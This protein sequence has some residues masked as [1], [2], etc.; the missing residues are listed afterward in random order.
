MAPDHCSLIKF[1]PQ[2][3]IQRQMSQNMRSDNL[4]WTP[5][6]NLTNSLIPSALPVFHDRLPAE[7]KKC[8]REAEAGAP[9]TCDTHGQS[10]VET[11]MRSCWGQGDR[12]PARINEG[13]EHGRNTGRSVMKQL[14]W[15]LGKIGAEAWDVGMAVPANKMDSQSTF[16]G[17]LTDERGRGHQVFLSWVGLDTSLI[18][19]RY[20]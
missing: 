2:T 8:K 14:G 4:L 18:Q 19:N 16:T 6:V 9:N 10:G 13:K 7:Q 12:H 3:G 15:P 11:E 20:W 1:T 17:S 5:C